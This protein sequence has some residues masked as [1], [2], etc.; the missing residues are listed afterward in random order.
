MNQGLNKFEGSH[1]SPGLWILYLGFI[2]I[3]AWAYTYLGSIIILEK[4]TVRTGQIQSDFIDAVYQSAA[5]RENSSEKGSSISSN[6]SRAFPQYTNGVVDPLFPWLI[7][8]YADQPPDIVFE[9]GKWF[10]LI[11]SGSLLIALGVA[12]ARAFSF[13]G[14]AAILLMGGFGVILERS[15]YF[16]S[17]AIYYLL[18]VL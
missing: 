18:V 17:D 12:A 11:F 7:L 3:Y 15:A 6:F 16:S 9:A 8:G 10:N 13:S 2:V 5:V 1:K 14:A 4:N